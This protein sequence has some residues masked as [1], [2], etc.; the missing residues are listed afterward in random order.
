M[1]DGY[2]SPDTARETPELQP[3]ALGR[4]FPFGV[5]SVRA[6]DASSVGSDGYPRACRVSGRSYFDDVVAASGVDS[7]WR[8][9]HAPRAKAPQARTTIIIALNILVCIFFILRGCFPNRRC[10]G[11]FATAQPFFV[12]RASSG[13]VP[14]RL[15]HCVS[16]SGRC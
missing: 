6:N 5:Q 3:V 1:R 13:R 10:S 14:S 9:W 2:A 4:V 15:S 8:F 11:V 7:V 16:G 12:P